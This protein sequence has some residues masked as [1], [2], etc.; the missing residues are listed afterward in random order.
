MANDTVWTFQNLFVYGERF[1]LGG[2][3]GQVNGRIN[4][5]LLFIMELYF[6]LEYF[7]LNE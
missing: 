7:F 4:N 5:G 6:Y 1:I 2:R 3:D